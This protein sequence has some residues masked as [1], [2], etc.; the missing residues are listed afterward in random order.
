MRFADIVRREEWRKFYLRALNQYKVH[1]EAGANSKT[2]EEVWKHRGAR[3]AI[4][5]LLCF[6]LED[7]D[8]N[9]GYQE[10]LRR[11]LDKAAQE[12]AKQEIR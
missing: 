6:D 11:G 9:M 5:N 3:E 4:T 7:P 8:E 2:I 12:V 10:K 1:L